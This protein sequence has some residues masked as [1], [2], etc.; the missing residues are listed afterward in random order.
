MRHNDVKAKLGRG[1]TVIGTMM[2]EFQSNGIGPIVSNAGAE[3]VL[4]DTEHTGW[5]WETVGRLIAA[6]RDAGAIPMVRVPVTERSLISR[7]LDLGAMGVMVPMVESGSQATNIV[8][9]AKYP[10]VGLRGAAFGVAHDGYLGGD[11]VS[12]MVSAN[13]ETLLIAQIE[14]VEGLKNLDEI[15]AVEGID[16]VWVGHFDLTNSMGIPGQFEHPEFLG[17]L[18]RVADAAEANGKSAGFMAVAVDEALRMRDRGYR[19]LAYGGDSSIYAR[20]LR[21]GIG[22]I[23]S[24]RAG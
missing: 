8:K 7:P 6:S 9:W 15:A 22:A 19:C 12:T 23:R 21:D 16:V 11:V 2:F 14:T 1:E 13:A 10:P 5:G 3:F 17:A 18:K 24:G 20:A 4:Y